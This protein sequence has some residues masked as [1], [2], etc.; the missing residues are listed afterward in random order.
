MTEPV[1]VA[2]FSMKIAFDPVI[3]THSGG[4]GILTGDTLRSAADLG[5]PVVGATLAH[6]RLLP[7]ALS[8]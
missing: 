6:P 1:K 2:D 3:P 5:M 4:L 8:W 7:A